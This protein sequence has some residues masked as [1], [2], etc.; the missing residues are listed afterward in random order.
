VPV[1]AQEPPRPDAVVTG[2]HVVEVVGIARRIRRVALM[3]GKLPSLAV[4]GDVGCL[5]AERV[6]SSRLRRRD[7]ARG[8]N[9]KPLVASE[10][11]VIVPVEHHGLATWSAPAVAP[12]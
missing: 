8:P 3:L 2:M 11:C 10:D 7:A 6:H 1:S 4:L 5:P 9:L 12:K